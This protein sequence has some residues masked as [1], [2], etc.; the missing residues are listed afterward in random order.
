[1]WNDVKVI[2]VLTVFTSVASFLLL[3]KPQPPIKS[4]QA[5]PELDLL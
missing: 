3:K 5:T 2:P 1:M 4:R